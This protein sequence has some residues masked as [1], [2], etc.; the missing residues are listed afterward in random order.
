[1]NQ[2]KKSN[3]K[4]RIVRKT[5]EEFPSYNIIFKHRL[6]WSIGLRDRFRRGISADNPFVVHEYKNVI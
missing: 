2:N 6:R 1:M 5:K 3:E 4:E